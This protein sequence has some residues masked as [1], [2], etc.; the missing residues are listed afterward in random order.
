MRISFVS[1]IPQFEIVPSSEVEHSFS[2]PSSEINAATLRRIHFLIFFIAT[3]ELRY[4]INYILKYAVWWFLKNVTHA[5]TISD[6]LLNWGVWCLT[7]NHTH[8]LR[9]GYAKLNLVNT[10]CAF[11]NY[12][13]FFI[14]FES[15]LEREQ[16]KLRLKR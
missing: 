2:V 3:L 12:C 16:E 13:H 8:N 11:Y 10:L 14:C 7:N 5:R 4:F 1:P 9:E 15:W 6:F